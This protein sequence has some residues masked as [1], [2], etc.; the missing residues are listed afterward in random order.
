MSSLTITQIATIVLLIPYVIL[1]LYVRN[2]EKIENPNSATICVD[3]M[4]IY[5]IFIIISTVNLE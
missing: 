1:E 3:L 5:L 4:L 2:C